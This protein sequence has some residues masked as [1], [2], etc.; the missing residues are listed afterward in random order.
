MKRKIL[1]IIGSLILVFTLLFYTPV[2]SLAFSY[3]A[4]QVAGLA[5]DRYTNE[6][7]ITDTHASGN[8]KYTIWVQSNAQTEPDKVYTCYLYFDDVVQVQTQTVS[9]TVAE[10]PGATKKLTFTGLNTSGVTIIEPEIR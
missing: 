10:I 9:W 7:T 1:I 8:S 4:K 2:G 5:Q 6:V 3:F